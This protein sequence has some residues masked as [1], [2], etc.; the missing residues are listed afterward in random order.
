M[1]KKNTTLPYHD[2]ERFPGPKPAATR[3]ET[4]PEG[5]PGENLT[6]VEREIP[7]TEPPA[8]AVNSELRVVGK[9]VPRLDALHKVTGTA[10]FTADVRLP[11]M[12]SARI[13]SSPHA[14]AKVTSIDTSA[15]ERLP[16]VHGVHVMSVRIG[17]AVERTAGHMDPAATYNV[18]ELPL[19][20]FAGQPIAGVAAENERIAAEAVKL[21]KVTYDVRP[22]VVDMDKARQDGAPVVFEENIKQQETGGGGGGAEGVPLEGNV[23]GPA[24]SS[25]YGGPR[26][27]IESGKAAADVVLTREYRTQ[28]QTHCPLET[29]G[30]VSDW[31]P[32]GL[33][34]YA[35]TQETKSVRNDLAELFE[36]P[37]A[38]VRVISEYTGGGFGAKYGAGSYGVLATWL[39]KKTG[40]PVKLMLSRWEDHVS[41]GNRPNSWQ[42]LTMGVTR[43]GKLTVVDQLSYGTAGVGLGAG[44]GRIAQAVYDCP[45]F[46]TRQYDVMTH[47][48][49]GAAFRAPGNVQGAFAVEQMMDELAEAISM[50]PIQ[51]RDN[52][53]P[54]EM[55]RLQRQ[56]GLA[57]VDWANRGE[58]S[59]KTGRFRKGL[60][61]GQGHWPRFLDMDSTAVVRLSGDGSVEVRSAVQ[62][63]GTGT[64]TILAQVVAEELGLRADEVTVKIGDTLYPNGPASG[65]SKATSSI[66]PAARNAAFQA[67]Q[68]LFGEV[69]GAWNV[70]V[71]DLMVAD[72]EIRHKT[73]GKSMKFRDALRKMSVNQ[74]TESATRSRDYGGFEMGTFMTYGRIGSVQFAEVTV[75]TETGQVKVDR[76][77][78]VHSCGRPINPRQVES[79][80]NGGVIQGLAYA[81]Y[82]DRVMHDESGHQINATLDTYRLPFSKEIPEI[83][84]ILIEQ[85]SGRTSTDAF[86]IAEASNVP[87]AA[88]IA[89]AVANAIGVRI[90]ELPITPAR[91]LA[92][93]QNA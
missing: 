61:V 86:G 48:G 59:Q 93:L 10:K 71:A 40:R 58:P 8:L 14:H 69:A 46:R 23:R 64:R 17:G 89:N 55:R 62:D 1:S 27:D 20:R 49:P 44:V 42:E 51:L 87:T 25:F 5:I 68:R 66:T 28:V 78:A 2:G 3:T 72:G 12:L 74:I 34:V 79:Q 57:R 43:A 73:N 60:G 84:S 65:G 9:S 81:L 85:Y 53:D 31:T 92:A 56:R 52:T 21:I 37:R 29:H 7:S 32:E 47:A 35:S 38:K 16:G 36:L 90:R 24:T 76:V 83:E 13:L 41:A 75:D 19:L 50:D 6:T 82:E 33:T 22:H 54:N 63:I 11:G 26:G 15:A 91:V 4:F 77:V 18:D 30:I 45:N 88:A 80:I 39:S 67:K 70:E